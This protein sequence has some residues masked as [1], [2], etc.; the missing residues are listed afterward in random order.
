[1][2]TNEDIKK[3][4]DVLPTKE[5]MK[6]ELERIREET[7]S[8]DDMR[9]VMTTL[10]KVLKEVLVMRQEQTFHTQKHEDID[11]RLDKLEQTTSTVPH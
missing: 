4:L 8:K 5:E 2:L 1:M 10:D 3:L 7:A 9:S 6:Q 11:Q